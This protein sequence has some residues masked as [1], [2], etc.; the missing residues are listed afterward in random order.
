MVLCSSWGGETITKKI[1]V[2]FF[3]TEVDDDERS[4]GML[5]TPLILWRT[6]S[7]SWTGK[8]KAKMSVMAIT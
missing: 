8:E 3:G 7:D 6:S 4:G 2:S 1:P 5:A